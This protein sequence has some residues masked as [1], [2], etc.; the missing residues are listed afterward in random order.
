MMYVVGKKDFFSSN[1][2]HTPSQGWEFESLYKHVL[3]K[4]LGRKPIF[5]Q[6]GETIEVWRENIKGRSVLDTRKQIDY[7]VSIVRLFGK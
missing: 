7:R 1:D 4:I 3:K 5:E 6:F 2:I